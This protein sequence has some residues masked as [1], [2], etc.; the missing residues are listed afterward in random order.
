MPRG[1]RGGGGK[2]AL[3]KAVFRQRVYQPNNS[4]A[5]ENAK[6]P[7]FLC[8]CRNLLNHGVQMDLLRIH[9]YMGQ[10]IV[11]RINQHFF[12]GPHPTH[13]EM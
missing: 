5:G 8:G 10:R 12:F 3:C 9:L 13:P 6:K 2:T 7:H 4:V 11:M 1:G